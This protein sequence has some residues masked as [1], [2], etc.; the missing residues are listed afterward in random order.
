MEYV[1][2]L[3]VPMLHNNVAMIEIC[4]R[5]HYYTCLEGAYV[6]NYKEENQNSQKLQDKI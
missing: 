4:W 3:N 2:V 5:D 6:V 1:L